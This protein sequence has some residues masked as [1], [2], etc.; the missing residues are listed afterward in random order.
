[1][2]CQSRRRLFGL[3]SASSLLIAALLSVATSAESPANASFYRTWSR[4]DKPVSDQVIRRTWIWGP[5]AFS[6]AL[7]EPYDEAPNGHRMVQYFDKSRMEINHD[8]NIPEL[9]P[10]RV[11]N[12]LLARELIT[13]EMQ[14][15]D[16]RFIP[17]VPAP[18]NVAG[19]PDDSHGPTYKTL[20]TLLSAEPAQDGAIIALR[21]QRNGNVIY[22]V[23]LERFGVFAAQRVSLTG[24]DHQIASVFWDFMNA[25]GTVH[26]NGK[27]VQAPLFPNPYYGT[28]YPITE[29][30]WANVK[31]AG[32]PTDV[33]I[34]CFERR[35]LT[36][37][38]ANAEG[39]QVEAGNIGRHYFAW[40]YSDRGLTP[41]PIQVTPEPSVPVST[42]SSTALPNPTA[43]PSPTATPVAQLTAAYRDPRNAA[44]SAQREI[45]GCETSANNPL[46][47]SMLDRTTYW[48]G[49]YNM[50]TA[51]AGYFNR[52]T[53]MYYSWQ[54]EV[55]RGYNSNSEGLHY[56]SM[57]SFVRDQVRTAVYQ[58]QSGI[59][60][61]IR[62]M[63]TGHDPLYAQLGITG[64]EVYW[65]FLLGP[66]TELAGLDPIYRDS[67]RRNFERRVSDYRAA[68]YAGTFTGSFGDY[69]A[70]VGYEPL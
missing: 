37:N 24:I 36:F 1:M 8:E 3:L 23:T 29:P 27:I 47:K 60:Q 49:M 12:G 52:D 64:P 30:Y 53:T 62:R 40:R 21:V 20:N 70:F 56:W 63:E 7:L 32:V 33:L 41:T 69:L 44:L 55:V 59:G 67:A 46:V 38:P 16:Q 51:H 13:G 35:C 26:E 65:Y 10:W 6:T 11:T 4:T 54:K 9:S 57:R 42:P 28:G 61:Q 45:C 22:D 66:N 15:G 58:P 48:P 2:G 34:Q 39:W 25:E 17:N 14:L 31:V 19:D 50:W 18:I 43:T 68:Q 5:E